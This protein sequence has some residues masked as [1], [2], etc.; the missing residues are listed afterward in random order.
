[1]QDTVVYTPLNLAALPALLLVLTQ[2]RL[3][4][5]GSCA[6]TCCPTPHQALV[7]AAA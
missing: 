2:P 1:M 7:A 5:V 3:H 6:L 4:S